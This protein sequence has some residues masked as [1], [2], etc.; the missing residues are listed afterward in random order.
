[1]TTGL[2]ASKFYYPPHRPDFVLRPHLIESLDAGLS[3]KLPWFPPLRVQGEVN[4]VRASELRFTKKEVA[5][6]LNDRMGFDL[7]LDGIAALEGRTEGW[8]ASLKLAALSMQGRHDLSEFIAK[9]SGSH[10]YVI[11]YLVDEVTDRQP[12]EVRIFLRRTSILERFCAPLC[13]H[14]VGGSEGMDIIDYLDR[15][16]L[17]LI[18]LDDHRKW[19]RYHHLF[20]DF[21]GQ[22][23]RVSEP[24]R[25]PELHRRASQWYQNQGWMDEAIQHA[26]AGGDLESATRLVDGIAADLIVR[27]E[28]YK[29][30]KYVEQLPSDLCRVTRCCASG[31]PGHCFTWAK[32]K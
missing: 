28:S 1:M 25:I 4:E 19:Y 31:M 17:F 23:L 11:D 13:E 32:W 16:N 24:D 10:R 12:E 5:T 14:V 22:R 15:S 30:V 3:G 6:F 7:S 26:L 20:A 27:R 18:P 29:L 8:V 9:F 21:L 2:L